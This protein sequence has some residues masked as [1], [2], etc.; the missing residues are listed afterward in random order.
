TNLASSLE[1]TPDAPDRPRTELS[2]R[3]SRVGVPSL[4]MVM[5]MGLVG[6]PLSARSV[7][8]LALLTPVCA[9]PDPPCG[10][11]AALEFVNP[12]RRV[13]ERGHKVGQS[14]VR[15]GAQRLDGG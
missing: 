1:S 6:A 3:R 5:T 9:G 8:V 10:E 13:A 2:R 15:L 7:G 14:C 11:G 12:V 4:A